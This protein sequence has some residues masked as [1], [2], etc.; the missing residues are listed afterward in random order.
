MTERRAPR[1]GGP[2]QSITGPGSTC[3]GICRFRLQPLPPR[4]RPRTIPMRC[5]DHARPRLA[6]R[7]S[8]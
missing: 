7:M 6:G 4:W 8:L 5:D 2:A 3:V 1:P